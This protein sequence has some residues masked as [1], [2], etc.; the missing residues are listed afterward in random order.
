[1]NSFF[2]KQRN[3]IILFCL[4]AT[5]AVAAAYPVYRA[6]SG[7]LS[8]ALHHIQEETARRSGITLTYRALS[9]SVLIGLKLKDI[10]LRDTADG[11]ELLSVSSAVLRYDV[12]SILRRDWRHLFRTLTIY[13]VV[14]DIDTA[15]DSEVI[16]KLLLLFRRPSSENDA[17]P[18]E[19]SPALA[20]DPD[21]FVAELPL[22]IFIRNVVFRVRNENSS[23]NAT[24]KNASFFSD[25]G[26]KNIRVTLNAM[27]DALLSSD[28]ISLTSALSVDGTLSDGFKNSSLL[29]RLSRIAGAQVSLGALNLLMTYEDRAIQVRSFQNIM[30]LSILARYEFDERAFSATAAADNL[31]L[32]SFISFQNS[33]SAFAR[34]LSGLSVT[35][36]A[37]VR[38]EL[39]SG[40]IAYESNAQIAFAGG[41][42]AAYTV[43]GTKASVF[44]PQFS[45][46][47]N[48]YH[49][50][51]SGSYTF[52][53]L[54]LDGTASLRQL[55]PPHGEAL[56]SEFFFT[57]RQR[58]FDCF[59][60]H[61]FIGEKTL[62]AFS[63]SVIPS[64]SSVDFHA[65][66]SDYSRQAGEQPGTLAIDGSYLSATRYLETSISAV[67]FY[68][69]SIAHCVALFPAAGTTASSIAERIAPYVVSTD[70]YVST[71]FKTLSY[72][73]PYFLMANTTKE[74]EAL[75][76]SLD[77][78]DATVRISYL[79]LLY[80]GQSVTVTAQADFTAT[81]DGRTVF[82][83]TE[84]T[85]GTIPYRLTGNLSSGLLIVSGD[86][87]LS[88]QMHREHDGSWGGT[89][90]AD[91]FPVA[92]T[93]ALVTI[94]THADF[95]YDALYGITASIPRLEFIGTGDKLRFN[96][97]FSLTG[98]VSP[99]GI[100]FDSVVYS[101]AYSSLSGTLH[102]V[103]NKTEGIFSSAHVESKLVH[104]LTAESLSLFA[105]IT[106]PGWE[107]VTS[108]RESL[109]FNGQ[110]TIHK[111]STNRFFREISDTNLC[112]GSIV[113]SGTLDNPFVALTVTELTG[114]I[115]G[116]TFS[117]VGTATVEDRQLSLSDAQFRYGTFSFEH[118]T[119]A[120][121]LE[122]FDG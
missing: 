48:R 34:M 52:A 95:T 117:A 63:M 101:D 49:A 54:Q 88:F 41:L 1:M 45:M 40:E 112:S 111:F 102:V 122:T 119:T 84:L 118:I 92:V 26:G 85:A 44:I 70:I 116:T 108:F 13:G 33:R 78:N 103:I 29:V 60:P 59:S 81:A 98:S 67:R 74:N 93:G 19:I 14:V 6:V 37:H 5:F 86:Y 77:G 100:F 4:C 35:G 7:T 56:S 16:E 69:D 30:P 80:R 121:S 23:V 36:G 43:S 96:P 91:A 18:V 12:L 27:V 32:L 65:E 9:P 20:F 24:L 115:S 50:E 104:P 2:A 82:F 31:A 28:T 76:L 17:A 120:V 22:A 87:G 47:G 62:S 66:I 57:P 83:S 25:R 8:T 46:T 58:G 38:Y 106:N 68:A 21:A 71:D 105:D 15:S 73:M 10:V 61:L 109:Y 94:S 3:G 42:S 75:L 72:N 79:N 99:Y 64:A 113:A 55:G 89:C 53:S 97:R 90:T 107:G 110:L 51:F 114:V 11:S 39:D